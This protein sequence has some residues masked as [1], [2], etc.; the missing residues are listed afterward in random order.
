MVTESVTRLPWQLSK[1]VLP[2]HTDH[3]GVMWHGAYVGWLEEA[4]V[5]ALAAVGLPY[6]LMALEG[7]EM[8]VVR[9]EMSYKRALLHGDQVVLLSQALPPEGPR[10]RWQ[11][12]LLRANGDCAFEAHVELVL[13][14]LDEGR[15]Q[16]L[17]RPPPSV[18]AALE[19]LSEGPEQ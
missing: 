12:R 7:L 17:R 16:V 4:R 11:T 9:L 6:R 19:R 8:P 14:R 3:G 2:Q 10:W 1:R 13:V 18:A 15:R 5:E